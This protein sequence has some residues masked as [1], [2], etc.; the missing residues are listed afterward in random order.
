MENR[1]SI[2]RAEIVATMVSVK[3]KISRKR[4]NGLDSNKSKTRQPPANSSSQA[5]L[6]DLQREGFLFF[7]SRHEAHLCGGLAGEIRLVQ[8]F[9]AE[10]GN[11]ARK[12]NLEGLPILSGLEFGLVIVGEYPPA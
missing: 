5:R 4:E 7:I 10:V 3:I 1:W 12:R 8:L 9:P 11:Q 6:V 2:R